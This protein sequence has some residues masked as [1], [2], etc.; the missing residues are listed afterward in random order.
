M[1]LRGGWT[2]V[3][4]PGIWFCLS[5]IIAHIKKRHAVQSNHYTHFPG[6]AKCIADWP[7][8]YEMSIL[9][10]RS[11]RTENIF[12]LYYL[13]T[14]LACQV[15]GPTVE[16]KKL[17]V[18]THRYLPRLKKSHL[19]VSA[20]TESQQPEVAALVLQASAPSLTPAS[21]TFPQAQ[22]H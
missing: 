6:F 21:L 16:L 13:P 14:F 9:L 18:L 8:V 19:C 17:K 7:H 11:L 10:L 5:C 20:G 1:S 4:L 2:S 22:A 12:F 15:W 3:S